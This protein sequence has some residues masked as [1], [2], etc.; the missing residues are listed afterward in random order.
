[1]QTTAEPRSGGSQGRLERSGSLVPVDPAA[2][3]GNI[4]QPCKSTGR[5]LSSRFGRRGRLLAFAHL[6]ATASHTAAESA[7]VARGASAA[8][9][10]DGVSKCFRLPHQQYHTLKQ[11][12]LHPFQSRSYD[13]LR[14]LNDVDFDVA[15]GEFFGIVG[16]NGSG[17][18]TLLKCLAGIYGVDAGEV[19]IRGRV[20]PFIELGVGFSMDLTARENVI[21]NAIML[22]LSR[23]Q[24]KERF[25]EIIA[26]AELEEFVDLNLR[27]YSSGMAVRLA[28]SV[29]V[30]AE[31]DVLLVDEVLAVGDAAF[32]QKCFG[33]FERLK[34]EGRTIIFVTHDMASVERFCDRAML[35]D[36]GRVLEIGPAE[37]ISRS[38]SELSLGDI[39]T[40][41]PE[42]L[43]SGPFHVLDAWCE[44]ADGKRIVTQ[45]QGQPCKACL[46]VGF[47]QDVVDPSFGIAFRNEARHPV[48]VAHSGPHGPSGAFK[49]GERVVAAF[50][51]GN[52]L[53][54][55]RYDLSAAV[56]APALGAAGEVRADDVATLVVAAPY[57]SGGAADIPHELEIRRP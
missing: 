14:A 9:S 40:Y 24:A 41:E 45:Q 1:M 17:K 42:A 19:R 43:G 6:T 39:A 54:S 13:E 49:A 48:F 56:A 5:G 26:F 38:Y 8:V 7:R 36:R 18:S 11:R 33:E 31:A 10:V 57:A 20:S 55:G 12:A 32:Q 2:T 51:F 50:S 34:S 30:Q 3:G 27:N 46:E 37:E 35:L 25:D 15:E 23:R 44:D 53:A 47:A 28:F 22:G 21:I 52:W 4:G 16:R 29:A